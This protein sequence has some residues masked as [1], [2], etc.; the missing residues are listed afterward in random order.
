MNTQSQVHELQAGE[1]LAL[2][3]HRKGRLVLV[4]GEVLVQAPAMEL[5]G[6]VIVPPATQVSAPAL[7]SLAEIG[8][9][10]AT[11]RATI[12]L[13]EAPSFVAMVRS[14]LARLMGARAG[15]AEMDYNFSLRRAVEQP[16]SS[17]GS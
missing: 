7:L 17:L 12:R 6:T 9:L 14:V 15:R 16:G 11:Q 1:A 4:Q 10:R 3:A 8:A 2:S 13:E 5:A